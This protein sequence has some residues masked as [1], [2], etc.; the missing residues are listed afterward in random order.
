LANPEAAPSLIVVTGRAGSGKS[1]LVHALGRAV[2]CPVISRDE[3]KEGFVNTIGDRGTG[4]DDIAR[5][6]YETF[7]ATIEMLLRRR[8]TLVVEAA[9]R[10]KVWEPKLDALR[11]LSRLRII[12]CEVDPELALARRLERSRTD[13]DR[14]RFHCGIE[15]TWRDFDP[16]KLDVPTLIVNT[17]EGYDPAF[18]SI[19]AF[20][21]AL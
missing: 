16:P 12:I 6:I 4:G 9:F 21:K 18:E 11:E 15:A 2:R 17:S 5:H 19:V 10:H 14:D 8:V 1:S 20:A 3:I 13:T 7:F